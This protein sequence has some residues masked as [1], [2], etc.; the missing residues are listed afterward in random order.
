MVYHT[1]A[2]AYVYDHDDNGLI[3]AINVSASPQ[4]RGIIAFEG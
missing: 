2:T 4:V 1:Y 3:T